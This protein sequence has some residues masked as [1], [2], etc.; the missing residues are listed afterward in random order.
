[1]TVLVVGLL[2]V[3]ELVV[4]HLLDYLAVH[5]FVGHYYLCLL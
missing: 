4:V 5:C 2:A 3:L 1:M